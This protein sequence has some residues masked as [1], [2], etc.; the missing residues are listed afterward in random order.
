MRETVK[1]SVPRDS[2]LLERLV[3]PSLPCSKHF[4]VLNC[5]CFLCDCFAGEEQP[6]TAAGSR[7]KLVLPGSVNEVE[8]G[9]FRWGFLA[10]LSPAAV[11]DC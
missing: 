10:P 6:G 2:S 7:G 5:L 9:E 8:L 4:P 11:W 1:Y 3:S